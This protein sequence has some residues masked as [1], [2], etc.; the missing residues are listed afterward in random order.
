MIK[1][2]VLYGHGINCDRETKFAV[3]KTSEMMDAQE[4]TAERVHITEFTRG[5]KDLNDFQM[6]ILPGGFLHGDDIS[7]GKIL[8]NKLK[9]T[10]SDEIKRFRSEKKLILGICNGFQV[11]VKYP[12]LPSYEKQEVTLTFND[13]GRFE[14][15]W[16]WLNVNEDASP[17]LKDMKQLYLPIRHAEGKFIASE[18]VLDKIE[19]KGQVALYYSK[20]N[21][22]KANG[23]FPYNPNGSLR[24]IAGL[25]DE[26]GRI[27]GMMPHPE[28]FLSFT[29]RPNWDLLRRRGTDFSG[30]NM[31]LKIF[32]NALTYLKAHH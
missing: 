7:A 6:L 8:A 29:N 2:A 15:R 12:L 32:E 3:E 28:A 26:T 5:T 13:S 25:C 22:K 24:D 10:L 11:L 27:F 4:V 17:F 16:T 31:A 21:G 30:Q 18:P 14:D 9:T 19:E 1:V 23:E 20:E